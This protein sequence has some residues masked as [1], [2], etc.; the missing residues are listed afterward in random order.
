MLAG[1][2][3]LHDDCKRPRPPWPRTSV[4]D[5]RTVMPGRRILRPLRLIAPGRSSDRAQAPHAQAR[6]WGRR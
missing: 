3:T 6:A 4:D 5:T 2:I 1:P